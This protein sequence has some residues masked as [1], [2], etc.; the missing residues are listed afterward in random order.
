[1]AEANTAAQRA[2]VARIELTAGGS[3][4]A[5]Q[6][7]VLRLRERVEQ[8]A[9]DVGAKQLQDAIAAVRIELEEQVKKGA[10]SPNDRA[11]VSIMKE[12]AKAGAKLYEALF[13]DTDQERGQGAKARAWYESALASGELF[14]IEFCTNPTSRQRLFAPWSLV[15][16]AS[17]LGSPAKTAEAM[18]DRF[19]GLRHRITSYEGASSAA[20][21][22]ADII[23]WSNISF[24]A[25]IRENEQ[26][27]IFRHIKNFRKSTPE[28]LWDARDERPEYPN[29][30]YYVHRGDID[31]DMSTEDDRLNVTDM[32]RLADV[33][34]TAR[35]LALIDG[36][37]VMKENEPGPTSFYQALQARQWAGF[38]AV[39]A[40]NLVSKN[41]RYFGLNFIEQMIDQCSKEGMPL[42]EIIDRARR[43]E[44]VRPWGLMFGVYAHPSKATMLI[45]KPPG[46]YFLKVKAVIEAFAAA[47]DADSP[48]NSED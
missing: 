14:D 12:L 24:F 1:M 44:K 16:P 43:S 34:D 8:F 21:Q 48:K 27:E 37:A 13:D 25:F 2:V 11:A 23:E 45:S 47:D 22:T 28:D 46:N 9:Y 31:R 15:Y 10:R 33:D 32:G 7:Q 5:V 3:A 35:V 29:S 19:W 40:N 20:P 26:V 18:H 42:L 38:I 6:W 30:L 39:E 17:E 41:L 36:T 4:V